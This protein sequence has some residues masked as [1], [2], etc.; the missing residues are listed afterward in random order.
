MSQ[1]EKPIRQP[2]PSPRLEGVAGIVTYSVTL[3][4]LPAWAMWLLCRAENLPSWWWVATPACAAL[5]TVC[6]ARREGG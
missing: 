1:N 6:R 2:T 4:L 5:L 3:T